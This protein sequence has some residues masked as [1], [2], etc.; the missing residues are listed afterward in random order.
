METI[1]LQPWCLRYIC[2]K[3][4]CLRELATTPQLVGYTCHFPCHG[5]KSLF[6]AASLARTKPPCIP[7]P[8]STRTGAQRLRTSCSICSVALQRSIVNPA[9]PAQVLFTDEA[10]FTRDGYFNRRNSHI[11]DDENLH[12]VFIRVHQA[13]FNVNTWGA[14]LRDYLLGTVII[15]D[16]LNGATYLQF[17]QNTLPLL[18]DEIPLRYAEKCGSNMM[19]LQ[20]TSAC[21]FEH[22][23]TESTG[24]NG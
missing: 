22:I 15:P 16:R 11:W 18:M 3:K 23:G 9:F 14:I 4:K 2:L 20:Y 10:C 6:S 21:E 7:P 24:R 13:R 5:F 1:L 12:A 8:E 17:H 19:A